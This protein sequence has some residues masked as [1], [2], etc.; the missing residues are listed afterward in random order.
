[1]QNRKKILIARKANMSLIKK[2]ASI[3]FGMETMIM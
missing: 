3:V 1:M 2:V